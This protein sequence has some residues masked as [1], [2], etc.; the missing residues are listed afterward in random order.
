MRLF[1]LSFINEKKTKENKE[2]K[3]T[4]HMIVF[5]FETPES[6][7]EANHPPPFILYRFPSP[8]TSYPSVIVYKNFWTILLDDALR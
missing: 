1:N 2:K 6:K 4:L 8:D 7:A 5:V 3:E